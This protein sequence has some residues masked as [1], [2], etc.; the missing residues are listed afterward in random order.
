MSVHSGKGCYS[1]LLACRTGER[2]LHM[3]SMLSATQLHFSYTYLAFPSYIY[4][5]MFK[6][7][8]IF[9]Y[10]LR[11]TGIQEPTENSLSSKARAPRTT[12]PLHLNGTK[13]KQ[14]GKTIWPV[15]S[16]KFPILKTWSD[17]D[18]RVESYKYQM[19]SPTVNLIG[20]WLVC[21]SFFLLFLFSF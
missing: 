5:S 9:F 15:F 8:F 10:Q 2:A 4:N 11:K 13:I 6:S 7:R 18:K 1:S 3:L 20:S 21:L 14:D 17:L 16:T 12:P 19:P